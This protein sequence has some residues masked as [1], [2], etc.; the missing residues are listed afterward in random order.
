MQARL[1]EWQLIGIFQVRYRT[2]DRTNLHCRAQEPKSKKGANRQEASTEIAGPQQYRVSTKREGLIP[3]ELADGDIAR[4]HNGRN[5]VLVHHLADC[6]FKQN[7]ELVEGLDL[8]LQLNAVYQKY[9]D[10]DFFSTQGIQV[11]VL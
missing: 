1:V 10:W 2:R 4:R 7:Y 6:V 11:G 5:A 8:A 9:R 3:V